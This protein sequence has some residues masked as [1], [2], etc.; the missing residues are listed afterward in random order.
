MPQPPKNAPEGTVWFGGPVD[1]SCVS[2][3]IFGDDLDPLEISRLL[4]CEPSEA[5]RTGEVLVRSNGRSRSVKH[6]FWR[7]DTDKDSRDVEEHIFSLLSRLTDDLSIWKSVTERFDVDLF[8]G[9]FLNADNRGFELS[10]RLL[11]LLVDR[12]LTVGFD[13]YGHTEIK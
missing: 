10:P 5:A 6:G 11:R 12:H 9:L 13:I 8:C 4:G 3:R 7:I 2:L 1:E